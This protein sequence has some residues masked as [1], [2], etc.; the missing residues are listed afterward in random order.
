MERTQLQQLLPHQGDALW[1]DQLL[2]HNALQIHGLSHW[3]YL[4]SFGPQASACY[5]FEAAAQLC[6]LHGALLGGDR[7][8]KMASIGKLNQLT[9]HHEPGERSG[10]LLVSAEQQAL[11]PGGA[12]YSFSVHAQEQLLLDG[13]MLLVLQHA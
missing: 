12:L 9:L 10:P 6:A 5:L 8:I 13:K 11:S 7:P 2:K 1:L 4:E 3:R